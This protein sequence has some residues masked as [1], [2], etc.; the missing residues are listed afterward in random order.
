[1]SCPVGACGHGADD[2]GVLSPLCDVEGCPC[3]QCL[4]KDSRARDAQ[5]GGDWRMS[6]NE[7]LARGLAVA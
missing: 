6:A 1:M 2:H 4:V 7:R 3:G 5:A